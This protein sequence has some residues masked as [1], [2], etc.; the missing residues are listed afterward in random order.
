MKREMWNKAESNNLIRK[1]TPTRLRDD[2]PRDGGVYW[3]RPKEDLL[4]SKS[5]ST[6]LSLPFVL[7]EMCF[8][9]SLTLELS[10]IL[11]SLAACLARISGIYFCHELNSIL[12]LFLFIFF[13]ITLYQCAFGSNTRCQFHQHLMPMFF[14]TKARFLLPK[15]C[16]KLR[17][18]LYFFGAKISYE[19]RACK[20]LMKSTVG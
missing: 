2:T 13:K 4:S 9:E 3:E 19:K 14:C 17:A 16:T 18:A 10:K 20:T 5:M 6:P 1:A 15:F 11:N 7:A 12:L 8:G